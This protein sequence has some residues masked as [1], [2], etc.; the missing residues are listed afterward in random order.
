MSDRY[1]IIIIGSGAG[2]GT[3]TYAL[4]DWG[5]KILLL[6]RGDFLPRSKDNWSPEAVFDRALYKTKEKWYDANDA[7][8]TPGMQYYVGGNTKVYGAALPRFRKQDFGEIRHRGGIAP[9]RPITYEELEPYYARAEKLYRVHGTS[10]EDPTEPPRSGDFPYPAV[11]HEPY[12]EELC[13]TLQRQGLHPFHY[14]MG[15]DL[16]ESDQRLGAC[17]RCDTCDGFPCLVNAKSDAHVNCVNPALHSGS[18]TLLTRAYATRLVTNA[19]GTQITS[20]EVNHD[21][22]SESYSADTV[23]VSCSAVNSAALLL[24]SA[25]DKHPRG[26]SN[27]SGLV[28]RNYM[29]HNNTALMAVHPTKRNTTVFQK[30]MAVNDFYLRGRDD[31]YPLGNVQLLG[32]LKPGMLTANKP[33]VPRPLLKELADRSVDWWVMSED[34]PDPNNR[35]EVTR[36]GQV[37][38]HW[39]PTNDETHRRLVGVFSDVMRRADYPLVLTERMGI[40]TCSHQV[41]TLRFGHDAKTSVLNEFLRSHEIPNLYVVDASFF[42]SSGAMNPALTIMAMA[43]RVADHLRETT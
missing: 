39:K 36:D 18:I 2:G 4:S 8:F 1:D 12:I 20:V 38:L 13:N 9:A 43:L 16:N 3:L 21:G 14:P 35:V 41:G 17:V 15:V 23:I 34:L 22:K 29:C 6:E 5:K 26:L 24:R 7:P 28:G 40:E 33:W 31:E 30:T 25:N 42:P 37:K 27:G 10:H 19:A 32:K 11:S